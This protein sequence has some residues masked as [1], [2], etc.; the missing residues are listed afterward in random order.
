MPSRCVHD[1][2]RISAFDDSDDNGVLGRTPISGGE[3]LCVCAGNEAR[4]RPA[5][6]T[7]GGIEGPAWLAPFEAFGRRP[8]NVLAPSGQVL[9]SHP[10]VGRAKGEESVMVTREAT[11]NSPASVSRGAI[12]YAT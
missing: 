9:R 5:C 6:V 4:K 2:E 10:N 3:P 7:I 8:L 12:V 11:T 1:S